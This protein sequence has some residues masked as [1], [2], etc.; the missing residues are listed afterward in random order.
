MK[1]LIPYSNRIKSN[2]ISHILYINYFSSFIHVS[3]RMTEESE[4]M[5]KSTT[6]SRIKSKPRN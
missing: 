1:S 3:D 6:S 4:L 5:N 2:I